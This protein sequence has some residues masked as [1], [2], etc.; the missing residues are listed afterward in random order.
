MLLVSGTVYFYT[1]RI[2]N[3]TPQTQA[4]TNTTKTSKYNG[5]I[6]ENNM[7]NS[8]NIQNITITVSVPGFP[9]KS[10]ASSLAGLMICVQNS[11]YIST[12]ASSKPL[13]EKKERKVVFVFGRN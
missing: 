10:K 12:S 3:T 2:N 8:S 13:S 11:G 1:H 9:N 5:T 4:T 6:Q 7:N